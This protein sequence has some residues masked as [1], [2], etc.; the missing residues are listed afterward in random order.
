[1]LILKTIVRPP[2]GGVAVNKVTTY[3]PAE[4]QKLLS[5]GYT[6]DSIAHWVSKPLVFMYTL[7]KR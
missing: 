4:V 5:D 3:D 6:L 7:S 1:M 2:K